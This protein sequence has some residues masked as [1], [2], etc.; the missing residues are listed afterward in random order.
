MKVV[1]STTALA[2]T[3]KKS[4]GVT[5][6]KVDWTSASSRREQV[7]ETDGAGTVFDEDNPSCTIPAGTTTNPVTGHPALMPGVQYTVQVQAVNEHA[8]TP[9]ELRSTASPSVGLLPAQVELVD[10]D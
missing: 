8:T 5:G 3:W 9:V 1:P 10:Q 4:D 7:L 6:Y 2:V